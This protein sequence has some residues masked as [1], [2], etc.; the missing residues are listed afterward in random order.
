M[1][2]AQRADEARRETRAQELA[3]GL[4]IMDCEDEEERAAARCH[5]D[6]APGMIPQQRGFPKKQGLV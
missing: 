5:S 1:T 3:E 6:A 4:R 2:E